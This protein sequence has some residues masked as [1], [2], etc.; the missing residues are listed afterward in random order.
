M[1]DIVDEQIDTVGK[2]F[3]GLTLGC[4]RC[5]DH[6]YDPIPTQD[7]YAL[8]GIFHS[9]KTMEHLNH[10]SQW[11]ERE[12]PDAERA[13]QIAEH[14]ANIDAARQR[15]QQLQAELGDP[16]QLDEAQPAQLTAA[17]E[18]VES[19]EKQLPALDKVMAVADDAVKLV[20]VHVRGS[21]LTM[22]GQPL[23]RRLPQALQFDPRSQPEFPEDESG[24]LELAEW[25]TEQAAPL[26]ARVIVNRIWQGHFGE[27]L[28]RT[29]SNFGLLGQPPTHPELLD[30]LAQQLIDADWS[31][32]FLHRQVVLSSTYRLSSQAVPEIVEQDPANRWWLR[33]PRRRLEI[34]PLRDALLVASGELDAIVGGQAQS[35][36]GDKFSS[37]DRPRGPFDAPRRTLYLSINRAA[38]ED[39]F[40]TFD[41][42]DPAVSL[43]KRPTTTVPH[44]VLFLQNHPLPM[45]SAWLLAERLQRACQSP[46]DKIDL[47]YRILFSRQSTAAE[48][49]VGLEFIEGESG[50]GRG[51]RKTDPLEPWASYCRGLILTNEF[52]YVD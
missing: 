43:E 9:T 24:R 34:E 45:H 3:L 15:L 17:K 6:K 25:L 20:A 36:Y 12:L 27:G 32:K 16:A 46:E 14:Q 41:Y 39:V 21:H 2:V 22:S 31:I 50:T 26:T 51:R 30:W 5:H 29:P 10:V 13:G 35:I 1:T 49:A 52:L 4:A 33:F 7:Y 19:L 8:A 18:E 28:V 23:P 11:N 38:L 44:Q 48:L 40:A 47:A 42:V 37:L